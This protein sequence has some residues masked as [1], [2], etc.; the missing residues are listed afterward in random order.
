MKRTW[1][2]EGVT[3]ETVGG[4][5]TSGAK[6]VSTVHGQPLVPLGGG[7]SSDSLGHGW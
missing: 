3:I 6:G 7:G 4:S 5:E 2:N 1:L